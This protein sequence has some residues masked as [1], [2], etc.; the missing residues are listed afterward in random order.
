VARQKKTQ[1]PK[2][3]TTEKKPLKLS[4]DIWV[5]SRISGEQIN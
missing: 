2:K 5:I 3:A 4:D 1:K